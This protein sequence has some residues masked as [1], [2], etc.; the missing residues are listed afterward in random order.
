MIHPQIPNAITIL[1]LT[2]V[3]VLV[4]LL[5]QGEF[6]WALAV[7]M[8]AGLSDGL[9]GYL[10]RRYRLQSE[11]GGFLDPVADKVLMIVTYVTLVLLGLLP[12]WLVLLVI[13]RDF[14]IIGFIM[15]LLS[16]GDEIHPAPSIYSKVNTVV[17]I[18][19]VVFVL[20]HKAFTPA[21]GWLVELLIYSL[22]VTTLVSTLNYYWVW[23]VQRMGRSRE[24]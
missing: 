13:A 17:Q 24:E 23:V 9:D 4:V 14:L 20:I 7:F 11:F 16:L 15:M 3:P 22:L 5:K 21:L 18:A 19:L 10:A 6:G 2:L 1:R 8:I 12:V